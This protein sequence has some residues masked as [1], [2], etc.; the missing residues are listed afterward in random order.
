MLKQN[1]KEKTKAKPEGRYRTSLD[2]IKRE[3]RR[4]RSVAMDKIKIKTRLSMA[5]A[6]KW[7]NL[8]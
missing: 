2:A 5:Q 3:K 6:G 7:E 1:G 4:G 8:D